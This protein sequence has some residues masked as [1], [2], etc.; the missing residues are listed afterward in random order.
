MAIFN[1]YKNTLDD[2]IDS[3]N[4]ESPNW[5]GPIDKG[6]RNASRSE[7]SLTE[8]LEKD[9]LNKNVSDKLS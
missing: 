5:P 2:L 9:C 8:L 1:K 7:N 6:S 3:S 4:A